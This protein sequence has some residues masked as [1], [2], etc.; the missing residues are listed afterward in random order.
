MRKQTKLVAV[1]STAALL[2]IGASMTSF[3]AQG[4]AEE[5]GTWVYYDR[6]GDRVTEEWKKSG[7]NWYWLNDDGEMAV[8]ELI[9]DDDDYYYVDANGAMV[10][11]QWVAVENEDAGDED[12]PDHYW[13][14]FQTNGKAF[15]RSDSATTISAKVINGK[16]YAFDEE[17]RMLYGWVTADGERQTGDDAWKA[18]DDTDVYYMGGEDDGAMRVNTWELIS[19][20]DDD[21]A[22]SLQ[23]GDEYWDE[24]QDRWFWFQSSGKRK[25]AG[26]DKDFVD[27]SIN[28]K[29]YG[30]DT[31]GR[32]VS[33]WYADTASL[34]EAAGTAS[35][36]QGQRVY[37]EQFMYFSS[38]EDGARYTKGWFK[39]V[40]GY[41]L[42]EAKYEDG[43]EYWYYADGDGQIYANK[44]KKIKGKKYA[45]DSYGRM[46]SGLA[47]LEFSDG[48]ETEDIVAKHADD[49]GKG[50]TTSIGTSKLGNYDTEDN[51]K[52]W[53][54]DN[55]DVINEGT[56]RSYYFGSSDDG[57]MK[58][59]KQTV[60]I[61]GEN[62]AFEFNKNGNLKGAGAVG[63]D[64]DKI[65]L[66][67]MQLKA[68]KDDK[69]EVVK[70]DVTVR[71][72]DNKKH[73]VQAVTEMST[74]AFLDECMD[75][76]SKSDEDDTVWEWKAGKAQNPTASIESIDVSDVEKANGQ[77]TY[78]FLLNS[79]GKVSKN[80]SGAKDGDDYKFTVNKYQITEVSLE[81]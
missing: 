3:A 59:G 65:Y 29:K 53:V 30:F 48:D 42:H 17:G 26:P 56:L 40:P 57:A 44:I 46:I 58:T 67:G 4:W 52:E 71:T 18:N 38:P 43:D 12:E 50:G 34:S 15:K 11:N 81:N 22:D 6:N 24:E 64:D 10:R 20:V 54:R 5:D 36:S 72:K 1:L 25:Q 39:V 55:V 70:V 66:A 32:M 19:I 79:S 14:Y 62:F 23:P 13:Y 51:F 7:D 41:Y 45:F 60:D 9:E 2:A 49:E 74:K 61:D 35:D 47:F 63:F 27:K 73:L 37:S 75:K 16:K 31:Y 28:G 78:Y 33:S 80:K 8:D 77:M 69:Y 68:D 76:S 21:N